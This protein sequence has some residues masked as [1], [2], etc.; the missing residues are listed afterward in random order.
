MFLNGIN[1]TLWFVWDQWQP[2]IL[3]L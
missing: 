3:C 1:F 2:F